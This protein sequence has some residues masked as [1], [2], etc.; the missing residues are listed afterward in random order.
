LRRKSPNPIYSLPFT[1]LTLVSIHSSH[2]FIPHPNQNE[3]QMM[4][5]EKKKKGYSVCAGGKKRILKL[6]DGAVQLEAGCALRRSIV[7]AVCTEN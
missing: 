7:R 1:H 6:A 3:N 2:Q 4:N 5:S